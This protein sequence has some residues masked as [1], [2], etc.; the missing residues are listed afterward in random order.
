M[1]VERID[2][3]SRCPG[4]LGAVQGHED[5][6]RHIHTGNSTPFKAAF[7]RAELFAPEEEEPSNVCGESHGASVD[8]TTQLAADELLE[9]AVAQAGDRHQSV[10]C[11]VANVAALR[12]VALPGTTGQLVHVY[13]DARAGN[14]QHS[15]IRCIAT[16]ADRS[17]LRDAI[18]K[19]FQHSIK[20]P[21]PV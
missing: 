11:L 21:D 7:Q 14:D 9:R 2:T 20:P 16:R 18:V 17:R 4:P 5:V 19:L 15:V 3:E 13:D 6:V 1:W 12:G 10:G 8:R